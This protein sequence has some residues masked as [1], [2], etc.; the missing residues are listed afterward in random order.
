MGNTI[1]IK[2]K[3]V[4]IRPIRTG[5]KAIQRLNILIAPM[6]YRGFTR[7]VNFP[8]PFCLE[9]LKLLKPVYNLI[10]K[11]EY[12]SGELNNKRLSMNSNLVTE[13]G[14]LVYAR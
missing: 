10:R 5:I 8:S 4:C 11:E 13:K 9:L 1:F 2:Y 7:I 14:N 6:G 12:F 3:K